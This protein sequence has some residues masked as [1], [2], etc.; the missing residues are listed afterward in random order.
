[1]KCG[2]WYDVITVP[3]TTS[4]TR[5]H[6]YGYFSRARKTRTIHKPCDAGHDS[7]LGQRVQYQVVLRVQHL[8]PV[9][10][11]GARDTD[12]R[13]N[14]PNQRGKVILI[15]HFDLVLGTVFELV[16]PVPS[17]QINCWIRYPIDLLIYES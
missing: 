2:N 7:Y 4:W 14:Q 16:L 15:Q 5:F 11:G 10:F 17:D 13:M 1:M 12:P 6:S 9:L 3:V 8:M